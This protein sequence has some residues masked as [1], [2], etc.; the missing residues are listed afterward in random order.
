MAENASHLATTAGYKTGANTCICGGVGQR[1]ITIVSTTA[2]TGKAVTFNVNHDCA[3]ITPVVYTEGGG[4]WVCPNGTS[5]ANCALSLKNAINASL[6]TGIELASCTTAGGATCSDGIVAVKGLPDTCEI[7]MT[8]NAGAEITQT[9]NQNGGTTLWMRNVSV[10]G[11]G[12]WGEWII[13]SGGRVSIVNA[14]T[15][16]QPSQVNFSNFRFN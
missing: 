7:A 5:T 4:S 3:A 6:P 1:I 9:Q 8:D 16:T 14:G 12:Y 10:D 15:T 13:D 2:T 11:G